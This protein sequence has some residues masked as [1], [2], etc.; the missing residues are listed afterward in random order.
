M[1]G[2]ALGSSLPMVSN[3]PPAQTQPR[4][5]LYH[6]ECQRSVKNVIDCILLCKCQPHAAQLSVGCTSG[7]GNLAC[8]CCC[9]RAND[10]RQL[11]FTAS[12]CLWCQ[13]CQGRQS[14]STAARIREV[15]KSWY[16]LPFA[17]TCKGQLEGGCKPTDRA[18]ST[19]RSC[20]SQW[21][22]ARY[23]PRLLQTRPRP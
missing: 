11:L 19:T 10:C 17:P 15:V 4:G 13:Q 1:S 7:R 5:C 8:A 22:P 23:H 20:F 14:S 18:E 9:F 2:F 21:R 3:R 12:K 16:S 6:H